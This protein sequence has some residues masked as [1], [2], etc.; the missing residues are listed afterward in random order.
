VPTTFVMCDRLPRLPS[1][2]VDRCALA[3]GPPVDLADGRP[4][5]AP[6]D[7][8]EDLLVRIWQELLEVRPIGVTDDFF[9]LGGHSLLAARLLARVEQAVGRRV[10]LAGFL[11]APIIEQLARALRS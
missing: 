4:M 9:D 8:A 6:R 10:P 5:V 1:G 7:Q 11:E 3:A 2:K